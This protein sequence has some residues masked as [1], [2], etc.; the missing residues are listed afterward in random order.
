[1][2]LILG[3]VCASAEFFFGKYFLLR[4]E[5]KEF[6]SRE[7]T[8]WRI[9]GFIAQAVPQKGCQKRRSEHRPS[10]ALVRFQE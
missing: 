9:A 6:G 5:V 2:V 1:M 3:C 4:K 10:Q 7:F 8:Q